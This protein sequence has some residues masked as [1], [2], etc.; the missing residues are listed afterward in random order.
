MEQLFI[1]LGRIKRIADYEGWIGFN[2]ASE[3][4][5]GEI[6]PYDLLTD[7]PNILYYQDK[8]G[9]EGYVTI[10]S[11]FETTVRGLIGRIVSILYIDFFLLSTDQLSRNVDILDSYLNE[12]YVALITN[13]L[14]KEQFKYLIFQ[15]DSFRDIFNSYVELYCKTVD[16]RTMN[17]NGTPKLVWHGSTAALG[18][19]FH[20]LRHKKFNDNEQPFLQEKDVDIINFIV[21]NFTLEGGKALSKVNL[22]KN[23]YNTKN[24]QLAKEDFEIKTLESR[25]K[26]N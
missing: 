12:V 5:S 16:N 13:E 11:Y 22:A 25:S 15:L 14:R 7:D 23:V 4:I 20:E 6:I 10:E 3:I 21:D 24:R 19:L 17:L 8:T 9:T 18:T 2:D 1:Y 26:N